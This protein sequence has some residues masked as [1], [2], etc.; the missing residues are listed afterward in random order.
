[1][2]ACLL[3]PFRFSSFPPLSS[4]VAPLEEEKRQSDKEEEEEGGGQSHGLRSG[5]MGQ[6]MSASQHLLVPPDTRKFS[7]SSLL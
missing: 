4:P 2:H 1:M 5:I 3:S 7:S 6:G